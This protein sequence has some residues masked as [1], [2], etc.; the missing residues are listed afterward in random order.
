MLAEVLGGEPKAELTKVGPLR[1]APAV[2]TNVGAEG[3]KDCEVWV[4]PAVAPD[5]VAP[6]LATIALKRR[7]ESRDTEKMLIL[8]C[9]FVADKIVEKFKI[10]VYGRRLDDI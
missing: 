10:F 1:N 6:T 7:M 5:E 4:T 8:L 3:V 2:P 9:D